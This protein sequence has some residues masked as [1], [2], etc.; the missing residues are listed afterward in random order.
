MGLPRLPVAPPAPPALKLVARAALDAD[1]PKPVL[2]F[3]QAQPAVLD[4]MRRE[5]AQRWFKELRTG[6][7]GVYAAAAA[8]ARRLSC[9]ERTVRRWVSET[10]E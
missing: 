7:L 4:W 10:S 8:V 9:S 3:L 1:L 6:G 2:D 5:Q